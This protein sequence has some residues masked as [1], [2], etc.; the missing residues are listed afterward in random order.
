MHFKEEV[1]TQGSAM[2]RRLFSAWLPDTDCAPQ[3]SR[4]F[5][6]F[7][8]WLPSAVVAG[9]AAFPQRGKKSA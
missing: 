3:K 7:R 5:R 1:P 2:H 9:R 8:R 6:R 4:R